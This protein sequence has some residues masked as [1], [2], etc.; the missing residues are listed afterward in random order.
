VAEKVFH[1]DTQ[2]GGQTDKNNNAYIP[3]PKSF[4]TVIKHEI[5]RMIL[6]NLP[7]ISLSCEQMYIQ[8]L[9]HNKALIPEQHPNE[10]NLMF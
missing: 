3:F 7:N 2:K 8:S 6:K 4:Y 5:S 10:H 9:Y 1:S